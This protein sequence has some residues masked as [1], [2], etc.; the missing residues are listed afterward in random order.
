MIFK[1][2]MKTRF[3][4]DYNCCN[5]YNY[6]TFASGDCSDCVIKVYDLGHLTFL[7]LSVVTDEIKIARLYMVILRRE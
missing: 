3:K 4:Q 5:W 1:N 7:S 2:E 6:L